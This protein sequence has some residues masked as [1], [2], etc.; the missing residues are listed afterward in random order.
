M[1]CV[2]PSIADYFYLITAFCFVSMSVSVFATILHSTTPPFPFFVYLRLI[3]ALELAVCVII[4][5]ILLLT[6]VAKHQVE[7][8][9]RYAEENREVRSG[10]S[11]FMIMA[12]G[13]STISA[14]VVSQVRQRKIRSNRRKENT[15]LMC[16]RPLRSRNLPPSEHDPQPIAELERYLL[17]PGLRPQCLSSDTLSTICVEDDGLPTNRQESHSE[18]DE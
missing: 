4:S 6:A 8:L 10:L 13:T 3:N 9:Q 15:R 17:E 1:D 16:N 14:A 5:L 12:A 18:P 2:T 7:E 11:V